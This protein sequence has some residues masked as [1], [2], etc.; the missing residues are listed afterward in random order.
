MQ[1][2]SLKTSRGAV[3]FV[4]P[5]CYPEVGPAA[6]DLG[7]RLA[8]DSAALG[9]EGVD[10]IGSSRRSDESA[11]SPT[12]QAERPHGRGLDPREIQV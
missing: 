11:G 10:R 2:S 7:Y 6:D 4:A 12:S 3:R 8:A 5:A 9:E 1:I